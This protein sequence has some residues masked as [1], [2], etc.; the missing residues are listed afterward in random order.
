LDVFT[1]KERRGDNVKD[2]VRKLDV[3]WAAVYAELPNYD[4]NAAD[5]ISATV[6]RSLD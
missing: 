5:A 6:V 1:G 4:V 2:D 3:L